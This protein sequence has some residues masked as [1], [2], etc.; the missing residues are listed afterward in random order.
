MSEEIK[1]K[2]VKTEHGELQYYRDWDCDGA[3]VMKNPQTIKRYIELHET[4]PKI[5]DYPV[6]FAFGDKQFEENRA[7][8]IEQGRLKESDKLCYCDD[9]PGLIGTHDG[10]TQYLSFYDGQTEKI[11]AEC[12][13]QEVYFREYNN[14]E[15]M[16]DWD[17]DL[18]AIK[19]CLAYF[20]EE[21]CRSI[22]RFNVCFDLDRLVAKKE[23]AVC[24]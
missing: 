6:F 17:G 13:P 11:T 24:E 3:V 18:Q 2:T 23:S 10:I 7:K 16:I 21:R 5:E 14:H 12:D 15:C 1:I 8:A 22:R 20:G 4:H 9:Y 19:L